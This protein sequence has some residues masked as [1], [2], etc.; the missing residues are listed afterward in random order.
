MNFGINVVLGFVRDW[1][2]IVSLMIVPSGVTNRIRGDIDLRLYRG[3]CVTL[4]TADN[5]VTRCAMFGVAT[6]TTT[7]PNKN[8]HQ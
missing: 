6:T 1:S 3:S 5:D 8:A 2:L 7:S 4:R